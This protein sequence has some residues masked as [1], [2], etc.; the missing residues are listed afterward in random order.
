VSAAF[1]F[2][3]H[4]PLPHAAFAGALVL[5]GAVSYGLSLRWYL[6][7]QRAFGAAR[8][9]S[10]FALAPFAGA[11]V[12]LG[13]GE[14]GTALTA[15]AG[16]VLLLGIYLHATERHGHEHAHVPERH[17][18]AHAH[19]DGHHDHVHG[20]GNPFAPHSHAHE[21]GARTHVHAHGSDF[22]HRHEH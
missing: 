3:L 11:L 4:E 2:A 21:H 14:R 1:A 5:I 12:S 9:A 17:E 6:A 8:S 15:L 7:A 20:D 22:H 10:V 19:D 16:A 18:H 13:L